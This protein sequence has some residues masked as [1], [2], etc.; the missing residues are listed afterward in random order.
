MTPSHASGHDDAD[1]AIFAYFVCLHRDSSVCHQISDEEVK[2]VS[3]FDVRFPKSA[4]REGECG[5]LTIHALL[6]L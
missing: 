6:L 4:V 1:R 5:M 3:A 2:T